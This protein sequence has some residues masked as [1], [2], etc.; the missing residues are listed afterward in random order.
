MLLN[1]HIAFEGKQLFSCMLSGKFR[2]RS[3]AEGYCGR[4]LMK[5]FV[6]ICF[7]SSYFQDFKEDCWTSELLL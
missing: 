7:A 6:M 4:K 2:G 3:C 5:A 1:K